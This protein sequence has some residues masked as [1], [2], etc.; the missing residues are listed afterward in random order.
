[1]I[2]LFLCDVRTFTIICIIYTFAHQYKFAINLHIRNC[3]ASYK[4]N[5]INRYR[6]S[7]E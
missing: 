4:I 6:F 5:P 1:M 7:L 2:L 3:V